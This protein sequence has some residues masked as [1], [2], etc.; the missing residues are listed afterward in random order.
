VLD[1][2]GALAR[3]GGDKEL[4]IEMMNFLLED[5][6]VLFLDL[7]E[8]VT[9]GDSIAVERKAHAL[10]GLLANGGGVRASQA[11]QFLEDAGNARNLSNAAA[12]IESLESE[13]SALS[14]AIQEYRS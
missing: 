14:A 11:A 3:L 5:G 8:A 7:R 10:K 13:L 4:F 2:E 6:P 1:I 9:A 12:L